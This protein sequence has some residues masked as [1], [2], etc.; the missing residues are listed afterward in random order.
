M[1]TENRMG[2][3]RSLSATLLALKLNSVTWTIWPMFI[4]Y[5]WIVRVIIANKMLLIGYVESNKVLCTRQ[6]YITY[7]SEYNSPFT[8]CL[9]VCRSVLT[10]SNTTG[11]CKYSW[12][13]NSVHRPT[14]MCSFPNWKVSGQRSKLHVDLCATRGHTC[15]SQIHFFNKICYM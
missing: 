15:L 1:T 8:T 5:Q 4:R 6:Q 3:F 13:L 14:S 12:T 7:H 10:C 2:I 11:E 9:S